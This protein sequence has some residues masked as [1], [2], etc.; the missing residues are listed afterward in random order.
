MKIKKIW[1]ICAQKHPERYVDTQL[2][3]MK[4]TLLFFTLKKKHDKF[5]EYFGEVPKIFSLVTSEK[6]K[7][8][9]RA[10]KNPS[11]L[12]DHAC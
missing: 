7:K 4:G 8:G 1:A 11:G 10:F 12:S 9:K 3:K 2:G 6:V 5:P